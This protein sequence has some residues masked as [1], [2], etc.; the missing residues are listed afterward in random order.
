MN[1]TNEAGE[2]VSTDANYIP[3]KVP[4]IEPENGFNAAANADPS[5]YGEPFVYTANFQA[6]TGGQT[7]DNVNPF[8]VVA[9]ISLALV[10][11]FV[12]M[13]RS[14]EMNKCVNSAKHVR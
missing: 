2:V 12:F 5:I 1:W 8:V 4:V 10:G 6:G 13:R 11:A 7:S 9:L 14:S 3:E